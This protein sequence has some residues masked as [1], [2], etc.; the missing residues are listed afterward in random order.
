MAGLHAEGRN[1][2]CLLVKCERA[3]APLVW[4]TF[5]TYWTFQGLKTW[6]MGAYWSKEKALILRSKFER[7]VLQYGLYARPEDLKLNTWVPLGSGKKPISFG[8][9]EIPPVC[10]L[11][12]LSER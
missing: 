3:L 9:K 8:F 11:F 4:V 1:Y 2:M 7:A 5:L 10:P 12:C 6:F